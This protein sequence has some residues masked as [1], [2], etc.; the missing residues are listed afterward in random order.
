MNKRL[1]ARTVVPNLF[2]KCGAR[3]R[4]GIVSFDRSEPPPSPPFQQAFSAPLG[5]PIRL[6][7]LTPSATNTAHN[8]RAQNTNGLSDPPFQLCSRPVFSR[9]SSSTW[10]SC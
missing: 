3:R 8:R 9:R 7:F 1:S 6:L 10:L 2:G 4:C 5:K